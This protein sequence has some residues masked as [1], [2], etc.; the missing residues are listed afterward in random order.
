MFNAQ[1]G[2]AKKGSKKI[3][4]G[5]A[6]KQ[7]LPPGQTKK[8]GLST[9]TTLPPGQVKKQK[10]PSM[11]LEE[12][13]QQEWCLEQNGQVNVVLSDNTICGCLTETHAVVFAS[14]DNWLE[15]IGKAFH[16]AVLMEKQP[17]IVLFMEPEEENLHIRKVNDIIERFDL[18][19]TTW[20]LEIEA[21]EEEE[22][23]SASEKFDVTTSVEGSGGS[24]KPF[25]TKQVPKGAS[26]SIKIQPDSGNFDDIADVTVNGVSVKSSLQEL[27]NGDG[28][29]VIHDVT[30]DLEVVATFSENQENK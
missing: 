18:P 3:P 25:G 13:A 8:Q 17:G 21:S 11:E 5:Q 16:S 22:E 9:G 28:H 1:V 10:I 24:I 6:K 23:D 2:I 27:G 30:E 19:I 29:L 14:E 15:S 20:L 7:G 12:T 26:I 4:P